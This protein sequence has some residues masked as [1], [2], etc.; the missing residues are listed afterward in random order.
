[1]DRLSALK[2]NVTLDARYA[3]EPTSGLG[4]ILRQLSKDVDRLE[5]IW[6]AQVQMYQCSV[7]DIE[8]RG[9]RVEAE[10]RELSRRVNYLVDEM[11]SAR[12]HHIMH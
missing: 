9:R 8:R 2:L 7:Q 4:K 12:L 1:M 3:E 5:G 11:R 6:K 10:Q